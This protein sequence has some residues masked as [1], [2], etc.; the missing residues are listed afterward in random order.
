VHSS[1]RV[2]R[3]L[4]CVVVAVGPIAVLSLS[5]GEA[6]ASVTLCRANG[7]LVATTV[8]SGS[9]YLYE[10]AYKG[11]MASGTFDVNRSD[12]NNPGLVVEVGEVPGTDAYIGVFNASGAQQSS[13]AGWAEYVYEC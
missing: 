10:F 2:R 4:L 9:D 7:A 6:A 3:A 13:V 12:N 8:N 1:E 5:G 11:A